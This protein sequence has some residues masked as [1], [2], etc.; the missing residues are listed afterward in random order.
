MHM[1]ARS[2]SKDS[3]KPGFGDV[4][5]EQALQAIVCA[6]STWHYC[7]AFPYCTP[8]K[9]G[10]PSRGARHQRWLRNCLGRI[11]G[12]GEKARGGSSLRPWL[13]GEGGG[14]WLR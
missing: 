2:W 1:N 3:S 7:L 5:T 8:I 11:E 12:D 9:Q 13:P 4:K 6:I 14:H 10:K